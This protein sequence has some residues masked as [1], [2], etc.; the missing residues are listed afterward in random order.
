MTAMTTTDDTGQAPPPPA[1][2]PPPAPPVRR[3]ERSTD[4]RI[5]AGVC[6][7]LGRYFD[8]DPVIFRVLFA[9]MAIFG[10]GFLLY[11][12]AWLF[13]PE[14]HTGGS[15]AHVV[16]GGSGPTRELAIIAVVVIVGLI[17]FP[18]VLGV[19]LGPGGGEWVFA[20]LLFGGIAFLWRRHHQRPAPAPYD[21]Q[22]WAHGPLQATGAPPPPAVPPAPSEFWSATATAPTATQPLPTTAPTEP[23]GARVAPAKP[24]REKSAL[25]SITLSVLLVAWGIAALLDAANAIELSAQAVL[26]GA[27]VVIGT[28][29]IVGAWIGRSRGLIALGLILTLAVSAV[30]A[31]D[32]PLTGGAGERTWRPVT[33]QQLDVPMRLAVGDGVLDLTDAPLLEGRHDIDVSVG[34]GALTVIVPDGVDVRVNGHVSLGNLRMFNEQHDGGGLDVS[35]ADS[36]SADLVID[37]RVGI[38]ELWVQ[39][40][41]S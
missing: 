9:V 18:G 20:L 40:E 19:G 25:G 21:A 6:G 8:V 41:A 26:G 14:E 34:I 12:A 35:H 16:R 7:G 27:L 3:L 23:W 38:G 39:R 13:V 24:P 28:G 37:A 36:E 31:L 17:A 2:E 4:D 22:G 10:A 30:G 5:V 32:V 1:P 29:L 11:G 33:T 15:V